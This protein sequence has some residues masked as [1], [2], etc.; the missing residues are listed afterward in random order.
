MKPNINEESNALINE[1]HPKGSN[2]SGTYEG[3]LM[4]SGKSKLS[5]DFYLF[6]KASLDKIKNDKSSKGSI[7]KLILSLVNFINS[8]KDYFTTSS[9]SGR[10][11]VNREYDDFRKSCNV[12]LFKSHKVVSPKELLSIKELPEGKTSIRFE[13]L[14]LHVAAKDIL[15]AKRF[16]D[17]IIG[18]GLKK[19]GIFSVKENKVMIECSST[20]IMQA[21]FSDNGKILMNKSYLIRFIEEANKKLLRTNQKIKELEAVLRK[22]FL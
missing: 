3:G 5:T 13:T 9:C 12:W 2:S 7:D 8:L 1:K 21:P 16:L 11:C 19:S 15:C 4:L 20:E 22:E 6:K 17:T 10:I 18:A 14:I